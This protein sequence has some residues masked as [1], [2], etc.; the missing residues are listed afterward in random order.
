L[1]ARALHL[2]R[3]V[4]VPP[5][6]F[7]ALVALARLVVG[8]DFG[9]ALPLVPGRP[10]AMSTSLSAALFIGALLLRAG[11]AATNRPRAFV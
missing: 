8:L 9:F 1:L 7:G 3:L 2:A 5:L 11:S 6:G 10:A 4:V